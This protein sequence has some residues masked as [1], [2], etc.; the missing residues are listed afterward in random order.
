MKYNYEDIINDLNKGKINSIVFSIKNYAHYKK[1]VISKCVDVI[2]TK[3][4]IIRIE[5]KLAEDDSETVSFYQKFKE[6]YKLFK[7]KGGRTT[8]LQQI[9]KDVQILYIDYADVS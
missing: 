3:K 7:V 4:N 2:S 9:W 6:D 5:V 8:T 1:C